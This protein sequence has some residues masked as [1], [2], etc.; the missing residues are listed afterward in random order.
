[1]GLLGK[2]FGGSAKKSLAT[3]VSASA[4]AEFRSVQILPRGG[5]ACDAV[6]AL[7]RKRILVTK[8]PKLPLE[9]CDQE[10]CQCV[11]RRFDDRRGELRR[12]ADVAYDIASQIRDSDLRSVISRGRRAED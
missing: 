1:M 9:G 11:Y 7:N 3:E 8:T 5:I 4:K 2:L 12:T 6:L 10:Q